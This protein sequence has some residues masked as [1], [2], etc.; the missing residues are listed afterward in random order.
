MSRRARSR[1]PARDAKHAMAWTGPEDEADTEVGDTDATVGPWCCERG[2]ALAVS[3]CPDCAWASVAYSAAM[4][5]VRESTG[6]A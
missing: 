5:P 1:A 4:A 2:Q 6:A 3:V